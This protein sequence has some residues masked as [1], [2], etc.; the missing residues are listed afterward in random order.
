MLQRSITPG[1]KALTFWAFWALP[2]RL[3]SRRVADGA[4]AAAWRG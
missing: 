4:G 3:I 2:K 1:R